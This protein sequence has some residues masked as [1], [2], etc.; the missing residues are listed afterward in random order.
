M[1]RMDIFQS[2]SGHI[3]K[4]F[5]NDKLLRLIEFPILFLGATPENTPAL[6]SLMNYADI[7]LGTW[8]PEGG[9]H[10][11]IEGML[12]LAE[13]KGV[14]VLTG[15]EVKEFQIEQKSIKQV[16]TTTATYTAD[17]IVAGADY[18]HEISMLSLMI[19]ALYYHSHSMYFY[20]NRVNRKP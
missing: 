11:I 18:H 4:F 17:I 2:F 13:E 6:Y 16:K 3:R 5:K 20:I 9:M 12:S 10:K 15:Q 7:S 8:Y 19:Q 14:E 1:L